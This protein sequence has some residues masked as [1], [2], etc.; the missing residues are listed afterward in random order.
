MS[1]DDQRAFLAVMEGGSLSA[2][3]R[4]LGLAQPTVRA[5]IRSLE[6]AL[7]T[8]LFTRTV[9][10]LAPTETAGAIETHA[11][12]MQLASDA[13]VRSASASPG[14]VSGTVRLNVSEFVGL[15]VVP[16]MLASLRAL[17]PDLIIELDLSNVEADLPGQEAD[18]AV[19]MT[20]PRQSAVVAR[21]VGEI[22]LGFFA[23]R[24]Y[25]ARKGIPTTLDELSGHDLVGPD[26][27][28]VDI[29]M[30]QRLMPTLPR[31]AVV[32]RTDNH[33]AQLAAARAALGIAIVQQP[34][35]SADER[36]VQVLPDTG[37]PG[38]QTW[39]TMHE[40]LRIVPRVRRLF[41]HLVEAFA[42]IAVRP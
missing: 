33:P 19:R 40:D 25:L 15:E 13:F 17:H 30:A 1:W 18:V 26:R 12:A 27:S 22:P 34:V 4:T 37:L 35:G 8:V 6:K 41:D 38:L 2:A 24:D 32:L 11:R 5:R 21:K 10:G 16:P 42:R 28:G 20:E 39:I 31:E 14:T 29:A 9:S 3:A 36:L 7:D 23:H